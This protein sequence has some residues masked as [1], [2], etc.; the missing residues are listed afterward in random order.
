MERPGLILVETLARFTK[1]LPHQAED[2]PPL[3]EPAVRQG[4]SHV[5][6]EWPQKARDA[7]RSGE[8]TIYSEKCPEE[9]AQAT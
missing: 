4:L 6:R 2:L 7:T 3:P 8:S 9:V 5:G 1:G